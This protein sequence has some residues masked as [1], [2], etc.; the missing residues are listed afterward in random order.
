MKVKGIAA[1]A[2]LLG[3]LCGRS[4]GQMGFLL[5][6][7]QDDLPSR[8]A[9][10][11]RLELNPLRAA[12]WEVMQTRL[13]PLK[14][15]DI[16]KIFGPVLATTTNW[17][18]YNMDPRGKSAGPALARHPADIVLPMFIPETMMVSGLHSPEPAGNKNHTDLHAVGDIGYVEF[19]Y[20]NDGE[21]LETA[22][23]YFRADDKF[24]P[25]VSTNDF[26]K[27]LEW[28]KAQL[29]CDEKVAG[30]Q[31]AETPRPRRGGSLGVGTHQH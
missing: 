9:V 8:M 20:A 26:A 21:R 28:E 3:A 13:F 16:S 31:L 29:G 23:L 10:R 18:V 30:G 6:F 14:L 11:D 4:S 5:D 19:Y 1:T 25:L 12:Y 15:D 2:I 17:W 7:P 27:R 24:I 22:L